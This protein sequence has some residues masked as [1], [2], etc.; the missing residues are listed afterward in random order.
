MRLVMMGTGQFAVPTFRALFAS[1]HEVVALF[2][3]PP[4]TG[5]GKHRTADNPMQAVAEERRL[6]IFWPESIKAPEAVA[7]LE[8]LAPDLLVVCDYGQI[9]STAALATARLGGINLHGS[10]LPKYRGAAPINWA[11]YN[12]DP[13]T[14]VTV[15]HMTPRLDAGPAIGQVRTPIGPTET[16]PQVETRLSELG[17]PAVLEAIAALA[18][19]NAQPIVQDE[20]L[21]TPAP[22]LTKASGLID[23]SRTA[24]QLANQVRAFQ[25]WP[26]SFT[27][28]QRGAGEPLRLIVDRAR[29]LD[30]PSDAAAGTVVTSRGN[31]LEIATGGGL[32]SIE[33]IQPAGK[34]V[35]TVPEF[36]NGYPLLPSVRLG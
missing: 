33:A 26:A 15:I 34:R 19:G 9:L 31:Q 30:A 24:V 21:A 29:P 13:E 6:P 18:A 14:G 36:L 22:R 17:A 2:T 35:F 16:T 1:G 27:F 25:P 5:A 28:W 10:L 8:S 3:R 7:Q 12:G 20:T 11:L 4:R 32:L 23:W